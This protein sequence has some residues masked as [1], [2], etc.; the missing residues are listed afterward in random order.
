MYSN[1]DSYEEE[2]EATQAMEDLFSDSW[3]DYFQALSI[4]G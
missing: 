1:L 2:Q 3:K 4:C